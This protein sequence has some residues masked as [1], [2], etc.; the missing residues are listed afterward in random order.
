MAHLREFVC[1]K[2]LMD[3]KGCASYTKL[4]LAEGLGFSR[5]AKG[6]VVEAW[7]TERPVVTACVL[8]CGVDNIAGIEYCC[9]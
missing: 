7:P 4:S 5:S 1:L 2:R 6:R 8:Q 9:R 3:E